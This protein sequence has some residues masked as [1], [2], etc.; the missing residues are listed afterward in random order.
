MAKRPVINWGGP[1]GAGVAPGG[2]TAT[3]AALFATTQEIGAILNNP[4]F[5]AGYSPAATEAFAELSDDD[6]NP[7]Q[8]VL[9]VLNPITRPHSFSKSAI[10]AAVTFDLQANDGVNSD[11]DSVVTT[12]QPR[13]YYGVDAD[14]AIVTE[15]GVEALSE[16][17]LQGDKALSY[18]FGATNEYVYYAFPVAY[19]AAPLDFQIGPF[20]GGFILLVASVPVTANTPG[21]PV[22]NYQIWRS[23]NALN[24]TISGDQTLTVQA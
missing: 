24:T 21:A 18:E 23:T 17:A 16:S 9:G 1:S 11:G 5:N 22:L 10:G 3:L 13:V 7:T 2:F 20:P 15:A 19:P 14:P 4:Q 12:W 6:G 8:D